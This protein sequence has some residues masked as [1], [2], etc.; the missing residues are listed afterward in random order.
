VG[1]VPLHDRWGLILGLWVLLYF[2]DDSL[3]L[4]VHLIFV[5]VDR[6]DPKTDVEGL[7]E[8]LIEIVPLFRRYDPKLFVVSD[9]KL[10]I[11]LCSHVMLLLDRLFHLVVLAFKLLI[12]R[13]FYFRVLACFGVELLILLTLVNLLLPDIFII[14]FFSV[15]LVFQLDLLMDLAQDLHLDLH[16][17]FLLGQFELF[18]VY[19][20]VFYARYLFL[21][22]GEVD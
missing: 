19:L 18:L 10:I 20:V 3:E 4:I 22:L 2:S 21:K 12:F 5:V 9:K 15:L 17:G 7:L 16:L 13:V 8:G 14:N 11:F 1:G 6:I